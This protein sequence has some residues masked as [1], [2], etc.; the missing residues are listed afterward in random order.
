MEMAKINPSFEIDISGLIKPTSVI[1]VV[2]SIN[3]LTSGDVLK[4]ITCNKNTVMSILSFCKNSGNT[5][6][7][8][9]NNN[10][11]ITLFIEKN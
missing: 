3:T 1:A 9:N 7:Q 5:L 11:E 8:K 2:Q 4:V 10:N 6:L